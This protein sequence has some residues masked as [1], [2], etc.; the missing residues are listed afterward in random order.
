MTTAADAGAVVRA[1]AWRA[2]LA[3]ALPGWIV[4]RVV[5]GVAW[6]I[7]LVDVRFRLDG[8]QPHHASLGLLAYDAD[9]YRNI[10]EFGY[11]KIRF[12]S[13]RFPPLLPVIGVNGTGIVI[14][15]NL[16][17]LLA[18]AMVHRLALDVTDDADLARRAATLVA[19]APPAFTL[20]WGY[21]EGPFLLLA[22]AQLLA[23]RRRRWVLAGGLGLLAALTRTSGVLLAVPAAVEAWLTLRERGVTV[24]SLA[25]RALAVLGPIAGLVGYLVWVEV[26]TGRG[27]APVEIQSEL[28]DGTRFPPFR[29]IE[30]LGEV[31]TDPLGDGLH[32]PFAFL[33]VFLVWV[34]WKRFPASWTA[35]AVVSAGTI[36]A[37]GLLNSLERYAH[38]TVPILVAGAAVSGGRWWRPVVAVSVVGMMG[39][40]ILA[41]YGPFVP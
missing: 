33:M 15:A 22:A 6:V 31:A 41:W 13:L 5:V 25:A 24:R 19:L 30:A 26:A 18:G 8:E 37:A 34:C 40:T 2:D 12:E 21:S 3:A 32:A 20:V 39:M 7:Q 28:R 36:L 17:A 16:C 29:L 11:E 35:L 4:A 9:V 23:L 14:V 38:G 27:M 1:P 10:A